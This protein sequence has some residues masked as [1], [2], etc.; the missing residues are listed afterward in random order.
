LRQ[1]GREIEAD[2][3]LRLVARRDPESEAAVT[4]AKLLAAPEVADVL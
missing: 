4:A 3:A 2:E 1:L